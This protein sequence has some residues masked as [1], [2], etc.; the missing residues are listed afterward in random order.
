[1]PSAVYH[2]GATASPHPDSEEFC[3][4]DRH[5]TAKELS[6]FQSSPSSSA[7]H[8]TANAISGPSRASSRASAHGSSVRHSLPRR[9]SEITTIAD[10]TESR[11]ERRHRLRRQVP[12]WYDPV[13]KFWRN[14]VSITIEEGIHRDHLALE[15]TFL[16]Y[17]RTSLAFAMTGVVVAQ[18]FRLQHALTPNLKFGYFILG[19]PLS[20][21]FICAA[22][23]VLLL[24]AYRFWRQ[25]SALVRGRCYAGGWEIVVILGI[26]LVL[27][28]ATFFVL[29]AVDIHKEYFS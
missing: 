9:D 8:P 7:A 20:A 3:R 17:L 13:S 12:R 6:P 18:L 15:R 14:N 5:R 22:I 2:F 24:G 27:C 16:A 11:D 10:E 25:Q 19:I 23:L 4:K 1:M 21:S 29:T 26:S 28:L